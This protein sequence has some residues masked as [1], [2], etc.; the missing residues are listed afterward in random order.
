MC[1]H[2][3]PVSACIINS[4]QIRYRSV[5]PNRELPKGQEQPLQFV[6]RAGKFPEQAISE[7]FLKN[8]EFR[9]DNRDLGLDS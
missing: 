1:K 4:L 6:C 9:M 3:M 8:R 7:A 5:T 2:V